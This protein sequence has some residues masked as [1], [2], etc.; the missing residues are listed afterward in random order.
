MTCSHTTH[1]QT[2]THIWYV[3]FYTLKSQIIYRKLPAWLLIAITEAFLEFRILT[4]SPP[5]CLLLDIW[6]LLIWFNLARK[7][8]NWIIWA[9]MRNFGYEIPSESFLLPSCQIYDSATKRYEVPVPLNTPSSP[10]GSPENRLYDV[11]LQTNPFGIQI[12]RKSSNTVV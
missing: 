7:H 11:S 9:G 3:R 12:R 4:G 6:C 5:I 1:S 2:Y 8:G 10:S